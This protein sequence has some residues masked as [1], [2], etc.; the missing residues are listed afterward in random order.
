VIAAPMG[1][2]GLLHPDGELAVARAAHAVG[3][4]CAV[5]CMS[6]YAL[7]EIAAA[8]DGPLW[9]QTYIWR[10]RG[11]LDELVQRADAAGYGALIVTVD[12]PRGANRDRDRRNRFGVPP[13][14]T[15][16]SLLDGLRHPR[17]SAAFARRARLRFGN[18]S[19]ERLGVADGP[20]ALAGFLTSQFDPSATWDDLERLRDRWEKPLIVKG[21]L[22]PQDAA[23]CASLGADAVVVS[24]HGGRQLDGAPSAVRALTAVVEAV[25]G[26]AEVY[27]DGGVRRGGDV[28]KALALGARA[29]MAGRAVGYGLGVAGQAGAER[30][31]TIL[32]DELRL[33]MMLAGCP[34]VHDLG[35]AWVHRPVAVA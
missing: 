12:V 21:V 34:S 31:L 10:D 18:F 26:R 19:G 33:A 32:A 3:V 23:R 4:V 35:P 29:C 8:G 20:A 11:L 24:N 28:V 2:L 17:F 22:D 5:S 7:E 15:A 1:A 27:V 16:R 30:A 9:F 14:A 6:S 13:R 25:D